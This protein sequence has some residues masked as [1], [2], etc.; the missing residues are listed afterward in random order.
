MEVIARDN[1]DLNE[2]D[3]GITMVK[4]TLLNGIA[5]MN[6]MKEEKPAKNTDR[7]LAL[8]KQQAEGRALYEKEIKQLHDDIAYETDVLRAKQTEKQQQ[9]HL[10]SLRRELERLRN[11]TESA[12]NSAHDGQDQRPKIDTEK[13][14]IAPSQTQEE[15]ERRK[16][17]E[18]GNDHIDELMNMVGLEAVKSKFLEMLNTIET[19]QR[20]EEQ[21]QG[22]DNSDRGNK[23]DNG[24]K[25]VSSNNSVSGYGSE[26]GDDRVSS[27]ARPI[28]KCFHAVFTG[29]PGTGKT[30]VA[31]LYAKFLNSLGMLPDTDFHKTTGASLLRGGT[32]AVNKAISKLHSSSPEGVLL[33]DRPRPLATEQGH[34]VVEYILHEMKRLQGKVAFVFSGN[35]R[36]IETFLNFDMRL[37]QQVH[38]DFTFEDFKDPEILQLLKQQLSDKYGG[39]MRLEMGDDDLYMRVISRRIGRGRGKS[40][41]G[42]VRE[43]EAAMRQIQVRQA[44]RLAERRKAHQEADD[45]FFSKTDLISLPPS[46][47]LDKSEAWA[48]LNKLIGL[49]SVK[50]AVRVFVDRAQSN[51]QRDIDEQPP[52]QIS[53]NKVFLGSPG[54]GKTTVAKLYGQILAD[55]GLLSRGEVMVKNPADFIGQALGESEQKTKAILDGA[56]GN[57]LVI[58]EAYGLSGA[59][60]GGG[61]SDEHTGHA[62]DSYKSAVI[63]T[64]VA[65]VQ[66]TA[67]EDR[68]VL[69]LGYK[70]GMEKLFQTV[71]PALGRRFPL[72]SA[73]EFQDYTNDEL[74]LIFHAKLKEAGFRATDRAEEAAM[75]VLYRSR[76]HRN[77]GNAGEVDIVLDRAKNNQQKRLSGAGG[78]GEDPY[79]F[80]AQDIDPDF[81]RLERAGVSIRKVFED[82]VGMED[83]IRKLEGYQRIV[84]NSKDLKSDAER[85]IPFSFLFRGP[86][87]TGKTTVAEKMGQIFYEMGFLATKD[88]ERCSTTNIIGEY[89]GHTGPK[90]QKVFEKALGRVLFIDEA[91]RLADSS[92]GRDAFAEVTTILTL[93]KYKNKMVTILAGYDDEIDHLMTVNPGLT[94]RFP[95]VINFPS[96]SLEHCWELLFRHVTAIQESID[97]SLIKDNGE[98]AKRLCPIFAK[99][100]LLPGWGNGRD[101]ETLSENI[102]GHMMRSRPPSLV[103]TEE[104]VSGE[105][106]ALLQERRRRAVAG[107]RSSLV[108]AGRRGSLTSF[109]QGNGRDESP[110]RVQSLDLIA[111]SGPTMN[112]QSHNITINAMSRVEEL[113]DDDDDEDEEDKMREALVHSGLCSQGYIWT[114][115]PDGWR[116]QGGSH[117]LTDDDVRRQM[118]ES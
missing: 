117:F 94:S 115:V 9:Q 80:E 54:T 81:D 67:G 95:E 44:T 113:P 26:S 24:N 12:S 92:F 48:G 15:W 105:M 18:S 55:I 91:Y 87:G 17:T 99:L 100:S 74:R 33:I 60:S 59:S 118:N 90:T 31:R 51:Y 16:K 71:N 34:E 69:L 83:L 4:D 108:S 11:S 70:E 101:V 21:I 10:Y 93:P 49:N 20:Q 57:V 5:E 6:R 32:K 27:K 7:W 111:T 14:R 25:S 41:F 75:E 29:N 102:V 77:F 72:S 86:P 2:G 82:F 39:K 109:L 36:D 89:V 52:V 45:F 50:Q 40:E 22:S 79:L 84:Q 56:K 112:V 46:A 28:S 96:M 42:N 98:V 61:S 1:L 38:F 68:C 13:W 65:E 73:F 107:R 97:V 43:V 116:C 19:A 106:N 58:D 53:L 76:N 78:R 23:S 62:A 88:V 85:L 64:L 30:T 8:H 110:E 35:K 103:L 47:V 104:T 63:D 114:R 66:S 3:M 37:R